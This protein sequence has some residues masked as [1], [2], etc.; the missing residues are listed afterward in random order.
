MSFAGSRGTIRAS[1]NPSSSSGL[2]VSSTG[3]VDVTASG[4][5]T[6]AGDANEAPTGTIATL[7]TAA[8]AAV[9][10]VFDQLKRVVNMRPSP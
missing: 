8:V 10:K 4:A 6:V 2:T 5:V 3:G 9:M 7:R 1:G